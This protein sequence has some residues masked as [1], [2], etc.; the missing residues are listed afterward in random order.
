MKQ[1]DLRNAICGTPTTID[2]SGDLRIDGY[3]KQWTTEDIFVCTG[4]TKSGL[5]Q[6]TDPHGVTV[7][8]PKRHCN[9]LNHHINTEQ[10]GEK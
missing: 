2:F 4:F 9:A 8:V 5:V 6:L 10:D 3:W 1:N 7:S